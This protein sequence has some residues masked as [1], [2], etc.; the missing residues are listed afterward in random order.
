MRTGLWV[1]LALGWRSECDEG[2]RHTD[3]QGTRVV[4]GGNQNCKGLVGGG[5]APGVFQTQNLGPGSWE[6]SE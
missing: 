1:R 5:G 4:D 3:L 2:D 6:G